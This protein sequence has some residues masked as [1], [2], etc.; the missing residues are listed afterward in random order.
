M[1]NKRR[2]GP[3]DYLNIVYLVL[4]VL[5]LGGGFFLVRYIIKLINP[6]ATL[7]W[8]GNLFGLVKPGTQLQDTTGS[9]GQAV[10]DAAQ[11]NAQTPQITFDLA[12]SAWAKAR[13][14]NAAYGDLIGNGWPWASYDDWYNASMPPLPT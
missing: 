11:R 2:L 13:G 1:D 6:G 8:W 7:A 3:R 10:S 12:R 9:L 5:V 14:L 4:A